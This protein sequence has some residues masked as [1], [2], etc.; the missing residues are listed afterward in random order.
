MT[1]LVNSND[2]AGMHSYTRALWNRRSQG[3]VLLF[4]SLS[5]CFFAVWH[6]HGVFGMGTCRYS[7]GIGKF[8]RFAIDDWQG[9]GTGR[10]RQSLVCAARV[11][12]L[13]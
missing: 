5:F 13:T 3:I 9:V 2:W 8:G 11:I 10:C 12:R 7:N 4:F 6:R 1:T